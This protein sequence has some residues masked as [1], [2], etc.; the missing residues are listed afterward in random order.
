VPRAGLIVIL[1]LAAG[2]VLYLSLFARR[3]QI[4]DASAAARDPRLLQLRGRS[5][6]VLVPIANPANAESMVEVANALAPPNI[7]RVLLLSVVA[8]PENWQSGEPPRQLEVSQAVVKQAMTA[9]FAAG[10]APEA[11]TTVA[12]LPWPEIFR[13][14]QMYRC[15]SLLLGMSDLVQPAS[16]KH[17][18]DLMSRIDSNVVVLRAP[19]G[20]HLTPGA[21]VLV[22]LG[23]RGHHDPLRAR[24]LSSLYQHDIR[25]I[26]FLQILPQQTTEDGVR[27][28]RKWLKQLA[29][30]EM[31]GSAAVEVV[32]SNRVEALLIERS[33]G[34]DLMILG[35]QRI[36]RY[37]KLF[38]EMVVGIARGTTCGLIL[39]N[40]KG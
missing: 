39:I 25:D 3:A 40:R 28:A 32:R 15:E 38:G 35:L 24:L 18:E 20:W 11:L 27:K 19:N 6:L 34:I 37:Q 33:A 17:L 14:A 31:P 2:G 13:V 12:P 23:G 7:G 5:P 9:S 36:G 26:T 8:P 16:L 4:V 22:P 30:D 21:T 1:W 10:L 29:R